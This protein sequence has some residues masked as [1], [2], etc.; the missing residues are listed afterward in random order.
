MDFERILEIVRVKF[1]DKL[2]W[3]CFEFKG[4]YIFTI[5]QSNEFVKNDLT[6]MYYA[7]DPRTGN[8]RNINLRL[9]MFGP[10][11]DAL[12]EAMKKVRWIDVSKEQALS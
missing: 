1:P 11:A 10:N 12:N 6:L 7:V 8:M 5:A 4:I 3:N 2:I 9:E